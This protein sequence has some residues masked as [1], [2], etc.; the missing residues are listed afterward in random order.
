MAWP[1]SL[2]GALVVG[3]VGVLIARRRIAIVAV[4]G[5]S[6]EPTLAPGDR[7]LVRRTGVRSVRAGQ[8]VVIEAPD[9]NGA[10][11]GDPTRRDLGRIWLIKRVAARPGEPLPGGMPAMIANEPVV[12]DGKLLLLGDNPE[13]S[14]DSRYL[15]YIPA[16]RLLGVVFG[17]LSRSASAS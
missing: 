11:T 5:Q 2:L 13:M 12:P 10:W 8:I 16:D 14:L 6:M 7:V 4:T 9:S 3:A 17:S 15:G 1:A